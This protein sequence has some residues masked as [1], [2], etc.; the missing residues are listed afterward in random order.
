MLK[1]I[2][3]H[4]CAAARELKSLQLRKSS[5]HGQGGDPSP[6]A[7]IPTRTTK[8]PTSSNRKY[9]ML[10]VYPPPITRTRKRSPS[11]EANAS[12]RPEI[13]RVKNRAVSSKRS[14]SVVGSRSIGL[15]QTSSVRQRNL[16]RRCTHPINEPRSAEF[17][18]AMRPLGIGQAGQTL[19]AQWGVTI[20]LPGVAAA[21]A[22]DLVAISIVA[23]KQLAFVDPALQ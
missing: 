19:V 14:G 11:T 13:C 16:I 15:G 18:T 21:N 7:P 9:V 17:P 6:Q 2:S 20:G 4:L 3:K 23:T 10:A 12:K 22:L 5:L 8:Q 1:H